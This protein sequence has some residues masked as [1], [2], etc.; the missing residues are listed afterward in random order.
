MGEAV[1][2]EGAAGAR[3]RKDDIM[4]RVREM[5]SKKHTLDVI[6]EV[7]KDRQIKKYAKMN[8]GC[9]NSEKKTS[10]SFIA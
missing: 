2:A 3:S 10:S 8:L 1:P 7:L 4:A 9:D 6:L 5:Q